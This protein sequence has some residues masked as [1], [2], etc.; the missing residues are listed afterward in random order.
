MIMLLGPT[1]FTFSNTK[2]F[3]RIITKTN[4]KSYVNIP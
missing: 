4:K 1:S 3:L 2:F